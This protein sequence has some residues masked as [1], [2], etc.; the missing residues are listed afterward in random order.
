MCLCFNS[1]RQEFGRP[2]SSWQGET[3]AVCVGLSWKPLAESFQSLKTVRLF[4][5][6][7]NQPGGNRIV[8]LKLDLFEWLRFLP[9]EAAPAKNKPAWQFFQGATE[10]QSPAIKCERL[11]T[12]WATVFLTKQKRV[13]HRVPVETQSRIW[14]CHACHKSARQITFRNLVP[15]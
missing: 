1:S 14:L 13:S 9:E 11:S 12:F 8:P 6:W 5:C 3:S 7:S 15:F 2:D 4:C 10:T